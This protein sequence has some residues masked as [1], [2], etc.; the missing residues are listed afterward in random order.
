MSY[1]LANKLTFYPSSLLYSYSTGNLEAIGGENT[2][3]E[4]TPTSIITLEPSKWHKLDVLTNDTLEF[5]DNLNIKA[6]FFMVLGHNFEA[7]PQ[8]LSIYEG[9]SLISATTE[10]NNCINSTPSFN[11]WSLSTLDMSDNNDSKV[12]TFGNDSTN[13]RIG[14][15]LYGKSWTAPINVNVGQSYSVEYNSKQKKTISG[16]TLSTLNYDKVSNWGN[17]PAWELMENDEN[18]SR[19][20]TNFSGNQRTGVRKWNV[21]FSML[22]DSDVLSQ[23]QMITN[24]G[25]NQDTASDYSL[26]AD[27]SSLYNNQ[28][29]PNFLNSVWKYT[30]G[31]HLPVVVNISD[32]KNADQWAIVRITKMTMKEKSPKFL[33]ISMVLEEQV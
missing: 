32:S 1:G 2:L 25:W 9:G 4:S 21:N 3:V 5:K 29:S 20:D 13:T 27:N 6:D 19:D 7:E 10:V 18:P 30:Q 24:N 16:K 26:G 11:G 33:D 14:S 23:N 15:I 8:G 31:S 17:L 12:I 28:N 22:N